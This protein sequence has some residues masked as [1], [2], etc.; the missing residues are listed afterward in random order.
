MN[1]LL[2]RSEVFPFVKCEQNGKIKK[3]N[4]NEMSMQYIVIEQQ[5]F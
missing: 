5:D 2:K 3:C 4:V 1:K